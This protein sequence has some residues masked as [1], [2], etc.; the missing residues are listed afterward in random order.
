MNK[1]FAIGMRRNLTVET[2]IN[3]NSIN[4]KKLRKQ[5]FLGNRMFILLDLIMLFYVTITNWI[6]DH[7]F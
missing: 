3:E 5:T 1:S 2:P 4:L 6:Y 7:I